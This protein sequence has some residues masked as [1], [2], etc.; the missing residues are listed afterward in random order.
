MARYFFCAARASIIDE[1]GAAKDERRPREY[2]RCAG[3]RQWMASGR[4]A[5]LLHF[6]PGKRAYIQRIFVTAGGLFILGCIHHS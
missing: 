6:I 1:T 5:V 2:I 4:M 3:A